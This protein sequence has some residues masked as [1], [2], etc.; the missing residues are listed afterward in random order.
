MLREFT[1]QLLLS[2]HLMCMNIAAAGPWLCILCE[3]QEARGNQAAGKAGR[4]LAMLACTL[5]VVGIV[6]GL[7]LGWMLWDR[8]LS[9]ALARVPSRFTFALWELS[10]I[11]I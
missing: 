10:L 9:A 8:G 11:H 7:A 5:L 4:H 6:P 3:W 1:L 2:G